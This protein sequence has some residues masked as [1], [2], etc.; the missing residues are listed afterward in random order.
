MRL[1]DI[2]S[3]GRATVLYS[4]EQQPKTRFALGFCKGSR[5][6]SGMKPAAPHLIKLTAQPTGTP[7]TDHP[8][9]DR[10]VR[11]NPLRETWSRVDAALP[12]GRVVCGVWRCEP[13]R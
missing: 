2:P 8:K 12:A 6:N 1:P 4:P 11:G 13:G 9:P 3:V 5:H 7:D 10:L